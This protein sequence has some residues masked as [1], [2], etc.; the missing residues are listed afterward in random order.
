M[1]SSEITLYDYQWSKQLEAQDPPFYGLLACLIRKA[2]TTNLAKLRMMW[3][4]EVRD[5]ERRYHSPGGVLPED[6]APRH[7]VLETWEPES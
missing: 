1:M 7:V 4:D 3:P 6:S 5:F 2:D